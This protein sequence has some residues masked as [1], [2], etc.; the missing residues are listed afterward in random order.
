MDSSG[1]KQKPRSSC[2][3]EMKVVVLYT[4]MSE[5]FIFISLYLQ[6][7]MEVSEGAV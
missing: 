1:R 7:T 5:P 3:T 2:Q 6:H 4:S